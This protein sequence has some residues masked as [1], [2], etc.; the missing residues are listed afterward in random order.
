MSL[1]S[2]LLIVSE[3]RQKK[4]LTWGMNCVLVLIKRKEEAISQRRERRSKMLNDRD[5]K[6]P[7]D[8]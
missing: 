3:E 7:A 2:S 5:L 4:E 1:M 6:G 8:M